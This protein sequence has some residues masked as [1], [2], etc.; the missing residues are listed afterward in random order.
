L[1]VLPPRACSDDAHRGAAC[2]WQED[3]N[4]HTK[5]AAYNWHE[6]NSFVGKRITAHTKGAAYN[7]QGNNNFIGK[8]IT[9]HTKG[10]AYNRQENNNFIGKRITHTQNGQPIMGKVT[11]TEEQPAVGWSALGSRVPIAGKRI[12]TQHKRGSLLLDNDNTRGAACYW[13]CNWKQGLWQEQQPVLGKRMPLA[14]D[15]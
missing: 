9:A 13:E 12:M 7:W 14:R 6:N 2:D 11:T 5:G 8:R 15:V 4:T 10:A 3:G 1:K